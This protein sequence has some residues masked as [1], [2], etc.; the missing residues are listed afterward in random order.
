MSFGVRLLRSQRLVSSSQTFDLT[1]NGVKQGLSVTQDSC[2]LYCTSWVVLLASDMRES[3]C[4]SKGT[5]VFL[6]GW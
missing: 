1:G 3:L 5:L 2:A 4:S 6:I